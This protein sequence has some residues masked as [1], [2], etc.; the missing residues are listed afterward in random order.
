MHDNLLVCGQSAYLELWGSVI[1]CEI[2]WCLKGQCS[3]GTWLVKP[4]NFMISPGWWNN[5][6]NINKCKYTEFIDCGRS[7]E[8]EEEQTR[9]RGRQITRQE[10]WE[11]TQ[12]QIHLFTS[13]FER[14]RALKTT[15]VLASDDAVASYL[16]DF[17]A[18]HV[19]HDDC[20]TPVLFKAA[21]ISGLEKLG[22]WSGNIVNHFWHSC[23]T[24]EGS[25]TV[26]RLCLKKKTMNHLLTY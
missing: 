7:M 23:K 20:S 16:L 19:Y 10:G 6:S 8:E 13:T 22:T 5:A 12:K 9:K 15:L 3:T 17:L 21:S 4:F 25:A 1:N 11:W 26:L 2:C 14:R 18:L 24:C